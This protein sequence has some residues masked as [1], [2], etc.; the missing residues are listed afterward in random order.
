MSW[1]SDVKDSVS[2]GLA[3]VDPTT[4]SG[5]VNL[6]TGGLTGGMSL[7]PGLFGGPT[8]DDVLQGIDDE[9]SGQAQKDAA[10]DAAR[11]QEDAAAQA[12]ALQERIYNEGQEKLDPFYQG[13]LGSLDDYLGLIDPEGAAAFKA[14]YLQ[15]DEFQG[16]LKQGTDQLASNAAFSG[17]LGSGGTLKDVADYTTKQSFGLSNQALQNELA[18]LGEGV[19]LG[20]AAAGSQISAGQNFANQAGVQYGNIGD[21][22][23]AAKLASAGS[24]IAPYLNLATTGLNIYK[25]ATV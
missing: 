19:G 12:L 2:D 15:G 1:F 22:Q 10:K 18:R 9:I 6:V 14:D 24:G 13:G 4:S 5:L 20:Q 7:I 11:K 25:G 17:A 3:S 16:Y 21:A 8:P 23:A